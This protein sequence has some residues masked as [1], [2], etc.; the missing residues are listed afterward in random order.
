LHAARSRVA[1]DSAPHAASVRVTKSPTRLC[2][3]SLPFFCLFIQRTLSSPLFPYTTLFR[4]QY[5][6]PEEKREQAD[7]LHP[8]HAKPERRQPQ[9]QHKR[10]AQ[11][12][13]QGGGLP[14]HQ[15]PST[16]GLRQHQFMKAP[17]LMKVQDTE[18][19]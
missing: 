2:V 14:G 5:A 8:F 9:T 10:G 7:I 4:S 1:S 19:Q 11:G 13:P 6:S 18:H 3:L 16:Y 12:D 15:R 17:R